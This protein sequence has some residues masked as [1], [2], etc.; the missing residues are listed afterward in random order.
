MKYE[1]YI[2]ILSLNFQ[3]IS[4]FSFINKLLKLKRIIK[5]ILYQFKNIIITQEMDILEPQAKVFKMVGP[6]LTKQSVSEARQNVNKR[7]EFINGEM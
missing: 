3:K 4:I 2:K 1:Y 5:L 6:V 7:I